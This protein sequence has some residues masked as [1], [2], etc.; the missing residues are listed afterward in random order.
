MELVISI[1][2]LTSS[3]YLHTLNSEKGAT[4]GRYHP[5]ITEKPVNNADLPVVHRSKRDCWTVRHTQNVHD[6]VA[7]VSRSGSEIRMAGATGCPK[8]PDFPLYVITSG[9]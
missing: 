4:L 5:D 2:K 1:Q 8:L 7:Q 3:A 6:E 9:V